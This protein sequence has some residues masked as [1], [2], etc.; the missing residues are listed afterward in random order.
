MN[1]KKNCENSDK[2]WLWGMTCY[3]KHANLSEVNE[4][5]MNTKIMV[6]TSSTWNYESRNGCSHI[7]TIF[8]IIKFNMVYFNI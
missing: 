5:K 8:T 7:I 4:K 2:I 6:K 3:W 1:L